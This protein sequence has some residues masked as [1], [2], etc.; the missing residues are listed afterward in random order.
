MSQILAV[1]IDE[2]GGFFTDSD[3]TDTR[4]GRRERALARIDPRLLEGE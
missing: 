4:L 3:H 2:D 1:I